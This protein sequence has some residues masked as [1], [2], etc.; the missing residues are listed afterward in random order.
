MRIATVRTSHPKAK[1]RVL[2]KEQLR[3]WTT[4]RSLSLEGLQIR[5]LM[6]SEARIRFLLVSRQP[7]SQQHQRS[8]DC[9]HFKTQ[10]QK[11]PLNSSSTLPRNKESSHLYPL[12]HTLSRQSLSDN[13]RSRI[14]PAFP[15]I[16]ESIQHAL[17]T[18]LRPFTKFSSVRMARISNICVPTV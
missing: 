18:T 15:S 16:T 8:T 11:I 10:S 1:Y 2:T 12:K 9:L 5:L 6:M 13:S 17:D 3:L 14:I 4:L 7:C